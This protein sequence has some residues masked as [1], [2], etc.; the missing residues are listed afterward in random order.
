MVCDLGFLASKMAKSLVLQRYSRY[1]SGMEIIVLSQPGCGPCRFVERTLNKAGLAHEVRNVR[2]DPEAETWLR[3]LY[4]AYRPGQR[5]STPVT[6]IDGRPVFGTVDLKGA[7][8]A[9]A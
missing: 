5:P 2:E 4:D 8:S 7:L 1:H 3:E 6:V 9:A